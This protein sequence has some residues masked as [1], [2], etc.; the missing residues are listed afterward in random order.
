MDLVDHSEPAGSGEA[1]GRATFNTMENHT[2]QDVGYSTGFDLLPQ[3]FPP[4]TPVLPKPEPSILD[5]I[6]KPGADFRWEP[7]KHGFGVKEFWGG[8]QVPFVPAMKAF[9]SPPPMI[10]VNAGYTDLQGI[11]EFY[12]FSIGVNWYRPVNQQW[13]WYFSLQPMVATDFNNTSGNM[14][15]VKANAFAFYTVNPELT[16][17]FGVLVTGRNDIPVLPLIGVV[18]YPSETTKFDITFP[19]PRVYHML[20]G[21]AQREQ[22][23]YVGGELGGGTWAYQSPGGFNDIL[24]YRSYRFA[25]GVEFVPAGSKLPGASVSGGRGYVEAGLAFSRNV[26]LDRLDV[27]MNKDNVFYL[28]G[29]V[30]F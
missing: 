11:D 24:T 15:R 9:G 27:D 30:Q 1:V 17:S 18:W 2:L 25:C 6:M 26:S 7:K 4:E 22:W 23:F 14:W 13:A 29:G 12:T 28:G 3:E 16:W 8:F 10:A 5:L 19:R 20:S 21:D